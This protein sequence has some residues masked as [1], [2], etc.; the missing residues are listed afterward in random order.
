MI[1]AVEERKA[2]RNSISQ[3]VARRKKAA[4]GGRSA[5][6]IRNLGEEIS[7][8]RNELDAR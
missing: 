5:V 1:Q 4:S 8:S 6:A 2:S 3:E 7:G